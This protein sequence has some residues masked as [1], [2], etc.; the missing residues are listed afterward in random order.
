MK[1]LRILVF[2]EVDI[3]I[4]HFIDSHAFDDLAAKHEVIFVF[5][6]AGNKRLGNLDPARMPLPAPYVRLPHHAERTRL[7]K[8]LFQVDQLRLRLG[9]KAAALRRLRRFTLGWKASMLYAALG[10]PGIWEVFRASRLRQLAGMS[11]T[12]MESLFDAEKPDLVVHPCVL[13]GLYLNDLVEITQKRGVP[14]TVIMNSW[15]NPSTK[16]AMV[17]NPDWLLVWGKQ[18]QRHAVDMAKI[19]VERVICFGAAQ[20]EVYRQQP[21]IDRAEF[22]R[23]NG[24]DPGRRILLY[25]GSSKG[26]DEIAHLTLLD[27]AVAQG[28]LDNA[29]ILYRPHPWGNGGKG[30]EKLL[31]Q[32]WQHVFIESSM[33]GYLED[34][35]AGKTSKYMADYRDTHDVLSH[36]DAVVSP[37]STI[38]LEAA[39]HSKPILCFLPSEDKSGHFTSDAGLTHFHDMFRMKEILMAAGY[40]SLLPQCQA[41]LKLCDDP[42]A[43]RGLQMAVNYFVEPYAEPYDRRLTAFLEGTVTNLAKRESP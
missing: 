6:E 24:V 8:Q 37:L 38:L 18:T 28:S 22:C 30:G 27:R 33:R 41:L 16:R 35:R 13:E 19:P 14:L 2:I 15:D 29:V 32:P 3:V 39:M 20:F 5:P 36:V 31:E 7:W 11:N 4:R 34:V 42:D 21:R 1:K 17:G 25:A 10:L 12:E 9:K 43:L 23:R 40:D 26:T